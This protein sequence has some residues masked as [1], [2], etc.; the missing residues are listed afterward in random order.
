MLWFAPRSYLKWAGAA[1][2]VGL[3]W[4]I[5]LMPAP[6]TLHPFAKTYIAAGS[7]ISEDLFEFREVPAGLL[8]P[9]TVEGTVRVAIT[10]GDPLVPSFLSGGQ[11]PVPH[12]WWALELEAPPGL[13]PG[14][15]VMLVAGGED[16]GWAGQAVSGIVIRPTVG[17]NHPEDMALI[18][19]PGE[20]V[21]GISSASTYGTLT[22]AVAPNR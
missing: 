16:P 13:L 9:T 7:H 19:V 12:G 5:Q 4:W 21:A 8:P 17:G 10:A 14:H 2:V 18:A 20:H 1:A 11:T 6:T 3:S 22:V 15:Q